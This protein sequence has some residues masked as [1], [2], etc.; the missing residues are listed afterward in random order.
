MRPGLIAEMPRLAM[1]PDEAATLA[2]YLV[3]DEPRRDI[4]GD[5]TASV[6]RENTSVPRENTASVPRENTA[7]VPRENTAS[8]TRDTP[9]APR[10][11]TA[12]IA[13]GE[14]LFR[15]LACAR[16][17]R[18][19]GSTVDDAA[20]HAQGRAQVSTVDDAA[21]HAQ[22]RAQVGTVDDAAPHAKGRAQ[23]ST[24]AQLDA[25]WALAPDLRFARQRMTVDSMA[26]WIANPRGAMPVL[27]VSA[28]SARAIALFI[29]TTPLADERP[30]A[31]PARLPVL[32]R[33]VRYAEVEKR[34]F[35]NLC[36]HCH[37]V[38]DFARGD[39]GPGNSG[40]FGFAPRGLDLSSYEGVASGSLDENG[41]RRSVFAK[42]P[43]G[44]PRI[45]AHLM[46]RYAE[47]AGSRSDVRG[48][49]LGLPPL[50]LEEIQL[51]ESWIA[52]GRPR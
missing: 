5:H 15:F 33:T 23:V 31:V 39:G 4:D 43:D 51:V 24:V 41:E 26:A 12:D 37:A 8:A 22:G 13:R 19:T 47:E 46:A 17:H 48:M 50:P 27:G 32:A 9:S 42:L 30:R 45:V 10:D 34:V 20:L 2:A 38:P 40:G 3:P 44:T 36:W 6:P 21:L 16:C 49:P 11:N 29:A 52:Q 7:S 14:Q 25:A 18:F 1:T 35:R 28:D